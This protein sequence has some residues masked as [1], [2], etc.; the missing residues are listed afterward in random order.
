MIIN[1]CFKPIT[2]KIPYGKILLYL[3]KF[4][5]NQALSAI[6]KANETVVHVL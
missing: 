2:S 1:E 5:L 4:F 6:V 3:H